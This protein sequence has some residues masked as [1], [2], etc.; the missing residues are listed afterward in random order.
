MGARVGGRGQLLGCW[1]GGWWWEAGVQGVREE[2]LLSQLGCL[3]VV[4]GCLPLPTKACPCDWE[5]RGS[6]FTIV[7][8]V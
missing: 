6:S 1:G 3:Q 2:A 7:R 5:S 4:R 8:N